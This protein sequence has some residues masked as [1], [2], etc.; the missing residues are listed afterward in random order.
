MLDHSPP[1]NRHFGCAAFCPILNGRMRSPSYDE[2]V[3]TCTKVVKLEQ[4]EEEATFS[5]REN[6][7][8]GSTVPHLVR[9]S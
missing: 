4:E 9:V 1:N 6:K 5:S 7:T 3:G 8:R 2:V